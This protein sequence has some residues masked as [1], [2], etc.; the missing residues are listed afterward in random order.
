MCSTEQNNSS[1]TNSLLGREGAE[2][3]PGRGGGLQ[4]GP[5]RSFALP[6]PTQPLSAPAG[7]SW[8]PGHSVL[9]SPGS[10]PDGLPLGRETRHSL[11]TSDWPWSDPIT[12]ALTRATLS[13]SLRLQQKAS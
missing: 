5:G 8:T 10:W 1:K 13:C 3:R 4:R 7:R 12:A 2:L 6:F 11:I 9:Q